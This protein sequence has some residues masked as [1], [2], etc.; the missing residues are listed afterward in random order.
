MKTLDTLMTWEG[1]Q[2]SSG[3]TLGN[4][5]KQFQK[6]YLAHLR[7]VAKINGFVVAKVIRG[8]YEFSTFISNPE[9]GKM[10]YLSISDVRNSFGPDEWSERIL[11]RTATSVTDYS[12]GMNQ[13]TSLTSLPDKL[14][15]LLS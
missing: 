3:S 11:V 14:E 15:Q 7:A 4:D 13:Y 12:G 1:H 2:F 10:L 6:A 5:Y 8:H 9:T